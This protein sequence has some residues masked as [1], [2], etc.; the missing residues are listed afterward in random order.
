MFIIDKHFDDRK[1]NKKIVKKVF[2][3]KINFVFDQKLINK[4]KQNILIKFISI[5]EYNQETWFQ[6]ILNYTLRHTFT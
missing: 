3:V 5:G 1:K 2:F 4:K 6:G